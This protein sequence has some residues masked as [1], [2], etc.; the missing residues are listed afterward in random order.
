MRAGR[1]GSARSPAVPTIGVGGTSG[2]RL[3]AAGGVVVVL[4]HEVPP[5]EAVFASIRDH[6]T[7]EPDAVFA[8][9]RQQEA[10]AATIDARDL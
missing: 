4:E 3:I 5:I 9:R 10:A 2:V 1:T 8:W 7:L 6:V